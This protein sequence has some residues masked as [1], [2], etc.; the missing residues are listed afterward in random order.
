MTSNSKKILFL[1]DL[2]E[3]GGAQK[4]ASILSRH[5]SGNIIFGI[6][7]SS[8]SS[9]PVG[10]SLRQIQYSHALLKKVASTILLKIPLVRKLK[11][12]ERISTTISFLDASNVAN[13][14]SRKK[15]KVILTVH[16]FLSKSYSE[17]SIKNFLYRRLVRSTYKRSDMV[18]AVSREMAT[19]LHK[20]FGVPKKKLTVI[21]N[22]IDLTEIDALG[23]K[24]THELPTEFYSKPYFI[25][26]GRL[27]RPK[28]HIHLIRAFAELRKSADCRLVLLGTGPLL[29]ELVLLA[30]SLNIRVSVT[31][32]TDVKPEEA[33]LIFLGFKLNPYPYLRKARGFVL[34]SLTEGFPVALLDAMACGVPLIS[35]DCPSGPKELLAPGFELSTVVREKTAAEFGILTPC[36]SEDGTNGDIVERELT[37]SMSMLL[38]N[39]TI[40]AKYVEK[41]ISRAKTFDIREI[42]KEW[43]KLLQ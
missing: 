20:N 23:Q 31:G 39:E 36:L 30:Q 14:L 11:R 8:Y 13:A 19:D 32:K 6:F 33:D 43:E 5:L 12:T 3:G 34:S 29:N 40:Y 17:N 27:V 4:A 25:S 28:G 22:P 41:S 35:T 38:K 18:V 15:D 37:A 26:A 2:M 24:P 42:L 9:F 7:N 1:I 21:Y 16:T 10:G